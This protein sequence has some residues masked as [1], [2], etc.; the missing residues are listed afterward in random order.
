MLTAELADKLRGFADRCRDHRFCDP[1]RL[2][3]FLDDMSLDL[4]CLADEVGAPFRVDIVIERIRPEAGLALSA[5]GQLVPVVHRHR[6][7]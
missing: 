2:L 4:R 3:M 5:K 6:R 7:R 1:E